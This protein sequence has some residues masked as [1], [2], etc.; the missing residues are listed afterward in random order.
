[1]LPLSSKKNKQI[2]SL[3]TNI[4]TLWLI[5][6]FVNQIE[7]GDVINLT[8]YY[9]MCP[10]QQI[11]RGSERC[12][13]P[14][15]GSFV[16]FDLV[17]VNPFNQMIGK[18][19]ALA[20]LFYCNSDSNTTAS[21]SIN[22]SK[23][24]SFQGGALVGSGRHSM[25]TLENIKMHDIHIKDTNSHFYPKLNKLVDLANRRLV[26]GGALDGAVQGRTS[27][28][29]TGSFSIFD[30]LYEMESFN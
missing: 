27:T 9:F 18:D 20:S 6:P 4:S 25:L 13:S 1:M 17:K 8:A 7:I 12:V 29:F 3:S 5:E 22:T 28:N 14:F 30:A 21:A 15:L 11:E 24:K 2:I 10:Q 19:A 26:K 23:F 16:A